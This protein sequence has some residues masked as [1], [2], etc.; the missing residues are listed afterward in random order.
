MT[1][2]RGLVE[3]TDEVLAGL[4]IPVPAGDAAKDDRGHALVVG[5]SAETAGGVLL[6]GL[7]ALRVGAGRVR[8]AT[9][10]SAKDSLMA[11]IPEGRVVGLPETDG[12]A[13]DPAGAAEPL[14]A[15]AERADVVL[16]GTG[17]LD[18][19]ATE[20][21]LDALTRAGTFVVVDAG[22]LPGAGRHPEW[23]RRL[24]GRALAIPNAGELELLG[25]DV[26]TAAAAL[27]CVVSARGPDTFVGAPGGPVHV[28]R[29]GGVGQA[30]AGSGD[31]AAGV[32]AG[33][34]ARGASPLAAACWGAVLHARAGERLAERVGPIGYL[35]RELLD[36]LPAL[37]P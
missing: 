22:A 23:V 35:A 7:A 19:D 20:P 9:V 27:G 8:L 30:T 24:D 2:Q 12:G 36:E 31:V 26:L 33:L 4:E 3:L 6:A 18:V 11:A 16:L 28:S 17:A 34:V 21:L 14:V 10:A 1:S 32:V 13:I 37:L 29:G 15:L 5:G 25:D